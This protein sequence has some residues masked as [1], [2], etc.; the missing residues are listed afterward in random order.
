[1]PPETLTDWNDCTVGLHWEDF[2]GVIKAAGWACVND[3]AAFAATS[4]DDVE[5]DC[6]GRAP[7]SLSITGAGVCCDGSAAAAAAVDS[8]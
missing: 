4:E 5:N 2:R 3:G 8:P 7:S 6:V 1:L